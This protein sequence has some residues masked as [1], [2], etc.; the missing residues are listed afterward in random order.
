M[1][2]LHIIVKV[3]V[4]RSARLSHTDRTRRGL[5][6][7]RRLYGVNRLCRA[8]GLYGFRLCR[9]CLRLC[10][11][12]LCS[13]GTLR[14]RA[15]RLVA[16]GRGAARWR[17]FARDRL[18]SGSDMLNRRGLCCLN[19]LNLY[20]LGRWLDCRRPHHRRGLYCLN[21]LNLYRLG[22]WLNCCRPYYR[23]GLYCLNRLNLYRLRRW[24]DCRRRGALCLNRRTC[25]RVLNCAGH[26]HA[27]QL[28][29]RAALVLIHAQR[30][31]RLA[32]ALVHAA[33]HRRSLARTAC[34]RGR[35]A[36]HRLVIFVRIGRGRRNYALGHIALRVQRGVGRVIVRKVVLIR[37]R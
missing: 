16:V 17:G 12:R 8:R 37:K 32:G 23:R 30:Q 29:L 18:L 15:A 36:E 28:H 11:N 1:D 7:A 35:R 22:R 6:R 21:R 20:R 33:V 5:C 27:G 13:S 10:L 24:L 34:K 26:V 25:R 4:A 14:T 3:H 2:W 9:L 31:Y 19:R